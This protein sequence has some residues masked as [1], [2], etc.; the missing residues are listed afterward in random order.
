MWRRAGDTA[1]DLNHYTKRASLLAVYGATIAVL[2]GD[3]SEGQA[4]ARAFLRR[5]VDDLLRI[6][7]AKAAL[8]GRTAYRPSLARFI[9]RLRYPAR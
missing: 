6:E 4:D 8:R 9:G 7:K 5:R 2:I 1:T 3:D